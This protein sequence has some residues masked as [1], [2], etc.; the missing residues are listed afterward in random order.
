MNLHT[1]P[2]LESL[3]RLAR[4]AGDAILEV[5]NGD[6]DVTL[7]GDDSP[8]TQ[9]DLRSHGIIAVGLSALAPTVPLISEE[10]EI[11]PLSQ[12]GTWPQ[13]WLVDPLDGT[14]EFINRNGEFTV[15]IALI[16]SGQAT[17]G[18]LH[19][20]L[21]GV[22]YWASA[23]LGAFRRERDGTETPIQVSAKA[24]QPLRV[25]GSRSHRDSRMGPLLEALGP[26]EFVAMGSAGKFGL[27]A[28]GSAD[29]YPRLGPTCEWDTAAGQAIVEA[30]GGRVV[31]R[32][33]QPLRYNC[34]DS[35][36]ND[37]FAV[38]GD[39]SRAWHALL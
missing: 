6:F 8:L 10:A 36:V 16:E 2:M 33:G 26:H 12:R 9:A 18:V 32:N 21:S 28:D 15:N 1:R 22:T 13:A 35:V 30:A 29:F 25:V 20:P 23:R 3:V 7:K 31:D 5:Y 14:K 19:L 24:N 34:R 37:D 17:L 39:L 27:V 38:Y 11:P 4:T